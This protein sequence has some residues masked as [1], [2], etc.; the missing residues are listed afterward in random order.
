MTATALVAFGD[1]VALVL[2]R[3]VLEQL[4]LAPGA[5]VEVSCENGT[6]TVKPRTEDPLGRKM[7]FEEAH[8]DIST[9]YDAM[10]KRLS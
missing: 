3:A 1:D 7:T 4:G 5:V 8:D 10:L 9:R 6:L 2:D